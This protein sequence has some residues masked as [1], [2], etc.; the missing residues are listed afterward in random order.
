VREAADRQDEDQ[1][2]VELD[3]RDPLA[4]ILHARGI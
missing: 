1:I 2:E 4:R 3:P